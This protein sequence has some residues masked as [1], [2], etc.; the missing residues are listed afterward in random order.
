MKK[1][2]SLNN[3]EHARADIVGD[4]GLI[5]ISISTDKKKRR[6]RKSII[7]IVNTALSILTKR[8]IKSIL[9]IA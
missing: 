1:K 6:R 8:N 7:L 9:L 2:K 4:Y 5:I 3:I